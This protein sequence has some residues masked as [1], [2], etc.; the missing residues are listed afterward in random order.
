MMAGNKR[1]RSW[2]RFSVEGTE[3]FTTAK[4]FGEERT[5][6]AVVYKTKEP[7][8]SPSPSNTTGGNTRQEYIS[9]LPLSYVPF[10]DGGT[11][12]RDLSIMSRSNP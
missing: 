7:P 10:G 11:R 2:Y 6:A 1:V 8:T 5:P 12:T 3:H 9:A 4:N